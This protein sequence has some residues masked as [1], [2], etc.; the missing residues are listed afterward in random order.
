MS[1]IVLFRRDGSREERLAARGLD[2]EAL[3][4]AILA[5]DDAPVSLTILVGQNEPRELGLYRDGDDFSP[6]YDI[7]LRSDFRDESSLLRSVRR[8][9]AAGGF[10]RAHAFEVE[11]TRVKGGSRPIPH[12]CQPGIHMMH[13]L[14][15]HEDLPR[16]AL[17]RSWR[18]IHAN[19]AAR[20]HVG[21]Q[22]YSQFLVL[23]R[24]T[25][26]P[27]YGGFSSLHFPSHHALMNGY[28]ESDRGRAEIRHDIRHFIRGL[29]PRLFATLH[30]YERP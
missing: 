3:A 17:L 27:D 28:F 30:T 12:G 6:P 26:G 4:G 9:Q 11:E 20:I 2:V 23:K 5:D 24:L 16:T 22:T 15:F 7:V 13:P 29:P 18:E 19:L 8:V 25:D 1:F 14:F 10:D 21:A